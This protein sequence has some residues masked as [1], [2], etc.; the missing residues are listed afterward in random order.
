MTKILMTLP[1]TYQHFLSAWCLVSDTS[2]TIN[3]L[4]ARLLIEE[5]RLQQLIL[6]IVNVETEQSKAFA[7]Q[8]HRKLEEKVFQEK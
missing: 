6:E 4:T 3:N 5:S 7:A 8:G 1:P 2:E